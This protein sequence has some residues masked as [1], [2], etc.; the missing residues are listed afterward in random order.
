MQM[1]AIRLRRSAR[2]SLA[3]LQRRYVSSHYTVLGV[4][5]TAS[6]EEIKAAFRKVT[7]IIMITFVHKLISLTARLFFYR[8]PKFTTLMLL[9]IPT[10]AH[11]TVKS[12]L[13]HLLTLV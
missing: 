11:L 10:P 7:I 9:L 4:A 5:P 2:S 13:P 12:L 1:I 6:V 3:A 8:K